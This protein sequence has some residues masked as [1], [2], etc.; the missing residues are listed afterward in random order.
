M[1]NNEKRYGAM[2]TWKQYKTLDGVKRKHPV[3]PT[4]P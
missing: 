4:K 2:I 3:S 1:H